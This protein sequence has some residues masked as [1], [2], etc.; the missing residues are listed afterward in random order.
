MEA[1]PFFFTKEAL[2]LSWKDVYFLLAAVRTTVIATTASLFLGTILG[3]LLGLV[4][5]FRIPVINRLPYIFIEPLRNSPLV[6]QLFLLYYGVSM[7]TKV[8][9]TAWQAAIITLGC[10]T[11]AFIAVV[12]RSSIEAI[13]RHQWESAYALGHSYVSAFVHIIFGQAFRIFI[14]PALNIYISQLHTSSLL[15]FIGF[16]E[17]THAG[18]V[19][20][21][22]TLRPFM[23]WTVVLLLYFSV[24]YP[25]SLLARRLEKQFAFVTDVLSSHAEE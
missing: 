5:T 16:M 2:E 6:V 18:Q 4:A 10:N 14:P 24:S 21:I 9:F 19:L 1:T 13:P 11:A 15:S 23:I 17:I 20:T 25:L 7:L 12:V 3:F 8:N 22:R